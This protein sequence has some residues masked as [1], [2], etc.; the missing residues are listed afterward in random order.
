M[1]TVPASTRWPNSKRIPPF[2]AGINLPKARGQS[3]TA[4]AEPVDV[5]SPPTKMRQQV[6]L[7]LSTAKRWSARTPESCKRCILSV[8]SDAA[9]VGRRRNLGQFAR[10]R[11]VVLRHFGRAVLVGAAINYRQR[12]DPV[13]MSRRRRRRPFERVRVP[14]ILGRL[15]AAHQAPDDVGEEDELRGAEHER[16]D[17]DEHVDGLQRL[18]EFVL[19][20]VVD[21]AHVTAHAKDMHREESTVK[22]D[23]RYPEVNLAERFVHHTP[24]HFGNQ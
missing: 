3:G 18:Q 24:E 14:R 2:H 22:R 20:W 7:A 17:R 4:S 11:Q 10:L 13:A 6:T 15:L 21:A 16:A 1:T 12:A 8:G 9:L 23:E 19:R 5:T